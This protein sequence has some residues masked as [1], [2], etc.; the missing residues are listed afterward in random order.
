M[1]MNMNMSKATERGM[2]TVRLTAE[3]LVVVEG[4][5]ARWLSIRKTRHCADWDDAIETGRY[6]LAQVVPSVKAL[7]D[8]DETLL[9]LDRNGDFVPL[10][11]STVTMTC[12]VCGHRTEANTGPLPVHTHQVEADALQTLASG[13]RQEYV[14]SSGD[15]LAEGFA[16]MVEALRDADKRIASGSERVLIHLYRADNSAPDLLFRSTSGLT[17]AGIE[18]AR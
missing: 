2:G 1:N 18:H 14:V 3:T 12:S 13:L 4:L 17:Q 9:V 8:T 11:Y 16:T 5:K 10:Q 15:K 7:L 6:M